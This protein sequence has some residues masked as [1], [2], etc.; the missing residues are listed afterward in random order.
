M[1]WKDQGSIERPKDGISQEEYESFGPQVD[2]S[3]DFNVAS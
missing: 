2:L 1:H 3:F